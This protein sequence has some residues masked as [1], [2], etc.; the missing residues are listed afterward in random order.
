MDFRRETMIALYR[1]ELLTTP[2]ESAPAALSTSESRCWGGGGATSVVRQS[3]EGPEER[4]RERERE[5]RIVENRQRGRPACI[6]EALWNSVIVGSHDVV[7]SPQF[8]IGFQK[9]S[10]GKMSSWCINTPDCWCHNFT[11]MGAF[12]PSTEM[13]VVLLSAP[14]NFKSAKADSDVFLHFCS[15]AEAASPL[16]RFNACEMWIMCRTAGPTN[17]WSS[18]TMS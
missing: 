7:V 9:M 18:V 6:K 2:T 15:S 13:I 14:P 1:T 3:E 4:E 10:F 5:E 8:P 17:D 11:V 16:C 12:F